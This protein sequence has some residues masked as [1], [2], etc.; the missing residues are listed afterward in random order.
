MSLVKSTRNVSKI[1]KLAQHV[2]SIDNRRRKNEI[3]PEDAFACSM[4]FVFLPPIGIP[5]T[6]ITM[7][8][9]YKINDQLDKERAELFDTLEKEHL[10]ND[11]EK[12]IDSG[13]TSSFIQSIRDRARIE[14]ALRE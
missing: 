4:L 11:V 12:M 6:I 7:R 10:Y 2:V 14:A 9:N 5:L 3:K 1:A 8:N 13:R